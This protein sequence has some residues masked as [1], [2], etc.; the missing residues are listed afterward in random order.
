[1]L[2]LGDLP[3]GV[4]SSSAS[5]VSADGSV[6]VGTSVSAAGNQAFRWIAASGMVGL[7]DLPGGAVRSAAY[8]VSAD[9]EVV[10]GFSSSTL[11][12]ASYDEAFRWT[13]NGMVGLGDL[14]GGRTNSQA[15][16]MSADGTVIVGASGSSNVTGGVWEAFRWTTTNGI[17][18]MGDLAGGASNSV[19]YGISPDGSVIVGRGHTG[20]EA[21][22]RW[23]AEFG[24][25]YLGALPCET[26]STA[27]AASANGSIVVGDPNQGTGDCAFVWDS[28]HGIR[29]LHQVL[30]NDY[31][32]NLAGWQLSAARAIT[33]DRT[34][35]VGYGRNPSGQTEAW[36][37]NITPPVLAIS[38]AGTNVVVSWRTNSSGFVLEQTS[39]LGASNVWNTNSITVNVSASNFVSTNALGDDQHFFR[40]RKP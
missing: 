7:G 26:W 1:M 33:P 40:L 29:N 28:Q 22:F 32:L 25:V 20:D 2:G 36:I 6:V 21:A 13:T 30:T 31:G 23:T 24:L 16:A 14:P 19:A 3:G 18:G 4:F 39:V 8:A 11:T 15:F 9:G 35:I 5:G 10:A 38:L 17:V 37:A 34:T 12:G 27:F